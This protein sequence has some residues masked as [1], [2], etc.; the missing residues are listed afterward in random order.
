MELLEK[1]L[2]QFGAPLMKS[3]TVEENGD[4]IVEGIASVPKQDHQGEDLDPRGFVLNYFEKSGWIKWEH[5]GANNGPADPSQFIGEPLEARIN[6][7]GEFYLKARIYGDSKYAHQIKEQ[8]ELLEKSQST[9]RMGFS[10]EGQALQRDPKNPLKVLKAIIRNVV[11]TMNPVNDGTWVALCKS[12]ASP[13]ALEVGL[14]NEFSLDKALDTQAA[15]AITP[16]SLEGAEPNDEDEEDETAKALSTFRSYVRKLL[17]KSMAQ[18]LIG[19][20]AHS[21]MQG[22]YD[23]AA[24]H[25]LTHRDAV[26]FCKVVYD[27]RELLKSVPS[28]VEQGG[29]GMSKLASILGESIDEL[30]KSLNPEAQ[31]DEDEREL[32]ELI[33]SLEKDGDEGTNV[34]DESDLGGDI[35]GDDDEDDE[36]TTTSCSNCGGKLDGDGKCPA[37]IDKDKGDDEEFDKSLDEIDIMKSMT[38]ESIQTIDVSE[39]L[40]DLVKSINATITAQM[41]SVAADQVELGKGLAVIARAMQNQNELI[42]SLQ[43]QV[44]EMGATPRGRRSA[45]APSEVQTAQRHGGETGPSDE[46]QKSQ[47]LTLLHQGVDQGAIPLHKITAFEMGY[48]IDTATARAVGIDP[49]KNPRWVSAQ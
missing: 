47:V 30:E 14:D 3:F 6:P 43:T 21:I 15:A 4:V 19:G 38:D 33:K 48:P 32:D 36:D 31:G 8:L 28:L 10:I 44:E 26:D 12:L 45:L 37:C 35:D 23:H 22:A 27:H 2:F 29:A 42:K 46:L 5:K 20:P 7:N 49:T 11:L 34:K 9:R 13:E 1:D 39:F 41:G 16:Q 17:N 40:G 24:D 25:G 18:A